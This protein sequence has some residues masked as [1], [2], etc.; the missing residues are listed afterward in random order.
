MANDI[1]KTITTNTDTFISTTIGQGASLSFSGASAGTATI[2]KML[3]DGTLMDM[4]DD[5]GAATIIS[6]FPSLINVWV[7]AGCDISIKTLSL[8]GTLTVTS[9]P[10]KSTN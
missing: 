7:G 3:P 4:T 2:Q 10:L 6:V 8:G 1:L 5:L 9:L